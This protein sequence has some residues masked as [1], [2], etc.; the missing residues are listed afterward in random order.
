MLFSLRPHINIFR[1]DDSRVRVGRYYFLPDGFRPPPDE[2]KTARDTVNDLTQRVDALD[3]TNDRIGQ[4]RPLDPTPSVPPTEKPHRITNPR[5]VALADDDRIGQRCRYLYFG[6]RGCR[7]H[8]FDPPKFDSECT[9][10]CGG[11]RLVVGYA[12]E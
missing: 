4:N 12:I 11:R 2:Q 8:R 6:S 9:D 10:F 1:I 3:P 5:G 7:R